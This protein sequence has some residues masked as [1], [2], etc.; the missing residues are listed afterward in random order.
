[1]SAYSSG[2]ESFYASYAPEMLRPPTTSL[3]LYRSI[4]GASFMRPTMKPIPGFPGYFACKNGNIYSRRV[5]HMGGSN[6]RLHRLKPLRHHTGYNMYVLRRDG[7]SVN[8]F[9][10]RLILETFVGPRPPGME[11]CHGPKGRSVSS[12]NNVSWGTRRK[13]NYDDKMRDG[14]DNRG[15]KYGAAKLNRLQVRIIRRLKGEMLLREVAAYFC[16]SAGHVWAIY[17]RRAWAWL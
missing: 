5:P 12:L 3:E 4:E 6:G 16:V 17:A 13:N 1:M 10:H 8:A 15:E 7:K 11:T 9:G 2:D 14:T